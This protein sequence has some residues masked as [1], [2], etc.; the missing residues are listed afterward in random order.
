MVTP[1][2]QKM[3]LW[4]KGTPVSGPAF[5]ARPAGIGSVGRGQGAVGTHIN[6]RIQAVAAGLNARQRADGQLA[7]AD[8]A[9]LELLR[10]FDQGWTLGGHRS[11][12][13][14]FGT[15]YSPCTTS[16]AFSWYSSRRSVSVASSGRKRWPISSG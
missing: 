4:A 10:Q 2:V 14:T 6:K 16:G 12:S 11:Y 5:A 15:R 13:M 3:S 1:R 9:S 7:A 8:V